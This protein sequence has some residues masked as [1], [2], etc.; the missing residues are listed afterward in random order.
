MRFHFA[1]LLFAL[2]ALF[3]SSFAICIGPVCLFDEG[4][5]LYLQQPSELKQAAAL[6]PIT[7]TM[8][9]TDC[10]KPG[11]NGTR[12]VVRFTF[13]NAPQD[14][15]KE[16]TCMLVLDGKEAPS[17]S[18]Y[19][20]LDNPPV[21]GFAGSIPYLS[22]DDLK[23]GC[24]L[25]SVLVRCFNAKYDISKATAI[26]DSN[27]GSFTCTNCCSTGA[28]VGGLLCTDNCKSLTPPQ[29]KKYTCA[30][31]ACQLSDFNVTCSSGQG[32]ASGALCINDCN[33][34]TSYCSQSCTCQPKQQVLCSGGTG[35]TDPAR[36]LCAND[37]ASNSYC[38]SECICLPTITV[39]LNGSSC[40]TDSEGVT[41]TFGFG[42]SPPPANGESY[43]CKVYADGSEVGSTTLTSGQAVGSVATNQIIRQGAAWT[44]SCTHRGRV[45]NSIEPLTYS[46]SVN[47][48]SGFG[49]SSGQLCV[50]DCPQTDY[51]TA[52]CKCQIKP[53]ITITA[54][55]SSC[56]INSSSVNSTFRFSVSPPPLPGDSY[57]CQI[58]SGINTVTSVTVNSGQTSAVATTDKPLK[59]GSQWYVSCRYN[60]KTF[61]SINFLNYACAVN[62]ASGTGNASGVTCKDDCASG[63]SCNAAC[64][65]EKKPVEQVKC[66]AGTG[67]ESGQVCIN[68]CPTNYYCTSSCTCQ[69][70]TTSVSYCSSGSGYSAI[71]LDDCS[72]LGQNYACDIK[73]CTCINMGSVSC[74]SGIGITSGQLCKND[75]P[76]GSTCSSDCKCVLGIASPAVTTQAYVT[77]A[78]K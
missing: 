14:T 30:S 38:N 1:L 51:C 78:T 50:D 26:V 4:G 55:G 21:P 24:G 31:C 61:T 57:S 47:C 33:S 29:Y 34:Q 12:T 54:T 40:K 65:C 15:W 9:V 18:A 19:T 43:A 74:S 22:S 3:G 64:A 6:D 60:S 2:I 44:A 41:S 49:N 63:F 17:F 25:H 42:V 45:F 56:Q 68:D 32:N 76:Q 75:C 77:W 28:S 53:N 66:S 5:W 16:V 71:C 20:R 52:A 8:S 67:N 10:T 7:L 27:S 46:C 37:C 72:R 70:N 35:I 73:S 69:K 58:I 13:E 11:N 39:S 23:Y 62:C 59:D 36:Q 48:A